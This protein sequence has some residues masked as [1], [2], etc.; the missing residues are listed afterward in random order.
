MEDLNNVLNSGDVP[1]IY[2]LEDIEN[3]SHACRIECQKRKLPPTK[4]NIFSQYLTRYVFSSI[5]L[6][7]C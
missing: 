2:A 6:S 1:N 4:L 7:L 5:V 3:I